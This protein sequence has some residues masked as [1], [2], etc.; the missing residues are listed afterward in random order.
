MANINAVK[1]LLKCKNINV[2]FVDENGKKPI[3][4]TKYNDYIKLLSR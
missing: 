2:N 1:S 3:Q 4:L